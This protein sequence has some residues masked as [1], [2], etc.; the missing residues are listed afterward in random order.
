MLV[1]TLMESERPYRQGVGQNDYRLRRQ[2]RRRTDEV[3]SVRLRRFHRGAGGQSASRLVARAVNQNRQ[4]ERPAVRFEDS[5]AKER[6]A[7]LGEE[8]ALFIFCQ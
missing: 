8:D 2:K 4:I 1:E 7:S 5:R 3:Y 6:Q